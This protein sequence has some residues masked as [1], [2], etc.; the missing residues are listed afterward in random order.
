ME[1]PI[2][3]QSINISQR[4]Q[5]TV[6][7]DRYGYPGQFKIALCSS[8]HH[9]FIA[10]PITSSQEITK[11]Y[12]EY[13]PRSTFNIDDYKPHQEIKGLKAW[14]NGQY[15]SA[16]RWVPRNVTVLDI[17]CG[18]GESLGYYQSRNCDA[19]GVEIDSNITRVAEKFGYKVHV[20]LFDPTLYPDIFFDYVTM[21]QVIEHNVDPIQTLKDVAQILRPNGIAI[22]STPNPNGWGAWVFRSRWINWHAPYHIH[23]FSRKSMQIAATKAG[24]T[25]EKVK[26]ITNSDWL[27]YQWIHLILFPKNGLSSV[28]WDNSRE[29]KFIHKLV[30]KF[31]FLFHKTKINHLITRFFDILGL[32]DNYIF[33]LKKNDAS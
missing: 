1:C 17:G 12:S 29:K 20:G 33:F 10:N 19:Y 16:F 24:L 25:L 21:D 11:L 14:L 32:G 18:F 3:Q 30:M 23:Y 28:F 9:R 4:H 22:L 27:L 7:D 5:L 31:M 6:F 26:V 2:C 13:Y 15:S 8:C